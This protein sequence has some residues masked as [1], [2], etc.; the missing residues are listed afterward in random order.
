[1]RDAFSFFLTPLC[2]LFFLLRGAMIC[3][4]YVALFPLCHIAP[5]GAS[6]SCLMRDATLRCNLKFFFWTMALLLSHK[7]QPSGLA[8][9]AFIRLREAFRYADAAR[10]LCGCYKRTAMLSRFLLFRKVMVWVFWAHTLS[11][12]TLP[13]FVSPF[14]FSLA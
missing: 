14:T 8:G 11:P 12:K 6:V 4:C 13:L 10:M 9:V 1:M 2:G 3:F 5:R 7:S